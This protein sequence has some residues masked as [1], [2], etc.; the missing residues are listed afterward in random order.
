MVGAIVV[1]AAAGASTPSLE[2]SLVA[3]STRGGA[4]DGAA[5]TLLIGA[6]ALMLGVGL[7][8]GLVLGRRRTAATSA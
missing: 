6:G 2:P 1:D 3:A 8:T 4:D 5:V 7:G